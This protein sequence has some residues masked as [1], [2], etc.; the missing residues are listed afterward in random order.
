MNLQ[1]QVKTQGAKS[2]ITSKQGRSVLFGLLGSGA[3]LGMMALPYLAPQLGAAYE[4]LA[5]GMNVAA[6]VFQGVSMLSYAGLFGGGGYL[7]HQAVRAAF[8]IPPLTPI[9]LA[10]LWMKRKEQAAI[11]KKKEQDAQ[12]QQ[13]AANLQTYLQSSAQTL[14]SGGQIQGSQQNQDGSITVSTPFGPDGQIVSGAPPGGAAG[15][16]QGAPAQQQQQGGG[17]S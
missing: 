8:L 7:D 6:N 12:Q 15:G 11:E 17:S 5:A 13:A 14:Q 2:L 1:V 10:A 3:F 4:T 16:Q 9:G